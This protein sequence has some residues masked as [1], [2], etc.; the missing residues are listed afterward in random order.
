MNSAKILFV[1]LLGCLFNASAADMPKSCTVYIGTYTGPKSKGIYAA[2]MDLSSGK[3]TPLGLAAETRNPAFLEVDAAHRRL[4]AA[5]EI[6]NFEGQHAGAVSAFSIETNPAT[7]TLLNQVSSAGGGP[8]HL[9]ITP[10]GKDIFVANYGGG[11]VAMLPVKADGTLGKASAFIQHEG[12]SAHPRQ[13]KPHAHCCA[14]D[15]VHHRLF[16]CDLGL[17][18]VMIYDYDSTNGTL[19]ANTPPFF[20]TL[21]GE[22]PRHLAFH[23]SDRFAYLV[24]ELDSTVTALAY[25]ARRGALRAFQ[26]ERLVP[27]EFTNENTA[28]EVAVHPSGNYLYASNR[29]HNSIAIFRIDRMSGKLTFVD[30]Q[31]TGGKTP[32]HF[33]IDPTGRFLLA[34]NQDSGNVVEFAINANT[35]RL[36][37]T[38][39]TLEVSAPV[40]LK[41]F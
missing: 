39:N 34:A 31:P 32:R 37:P 30:R 35:G 29:G 18:K 19:T 10:D 41:F 4:Y 5:N 27:K 1:L 3:L 12:K 6:G 16:V 11:S 38:G 26:T 9:A 25:D 28:A 24:S 17:D 20:T 7:L 23:P 14:L 40:C 15:A 22:G 8:C 2:R 21:P 36:T 33:A 13:E